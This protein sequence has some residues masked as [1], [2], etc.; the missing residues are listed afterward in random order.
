MMPEPMMLLL[1]IMVGVLLG[2]IFFGGLWWTIRRALAS[3]QPALWVFI[4]LPLRVGIA[5][6]GFL[7]MAPGGWQRVLWCL[8]GFVLARLAVTWLTRL[9]SVQRATPA[10]EASHASES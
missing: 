7:L 2:T 8:L 10:Q 5:V 3:R 1:S 6:G 9:P 4:S